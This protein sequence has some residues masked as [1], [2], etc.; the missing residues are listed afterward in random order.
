MQRPASS[1]SYFGI[2][3]LIRRLNFYMREGI[4]RNMEGKKV[5]FLFVVTNLVY[6]FMLTVTIPKVMLHAGGLKIFDMMPMGY[7]QQYALT[8]LEK[9][10]A[11]GRRVYLYN[12]IPVD[13]IY[14]FLF[15]ITY[16][17]L[18]AY[19]LNKLNRLK[20]EGFYL[21][22]LPLFAG[23]F[24]YLENFSIINML[25]SY[26]QLSDKAIHTATFFTVFKSLFSTISF[27]VLIV[28]LVFYG[29]H[30]LFVKR[31]VVH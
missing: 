31:K 24:D 13:L 17:L 27:A 12:Q 15:G 21:C 22:V 2:R 10:G 28:M 7:D 18:L 25:V 5:L 29:Y 8:L 1:F 4:Y 6:V 26:P 14:P 11:E 23:L 16:C 20:A 3:L 19:L 30:K 9:L